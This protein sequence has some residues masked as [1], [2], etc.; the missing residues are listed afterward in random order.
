MPAV[1]L[2]MTNLGEAFSVKVCLD[3]SALVKR[4]IEA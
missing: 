1:G 4:D 3:D 2:R